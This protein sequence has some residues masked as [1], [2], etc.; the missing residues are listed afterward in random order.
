MR[1]VNVKILFGQLPHTK[2][3]NR[4]KKFYLKNSIASLLIIT[5]YHLLIATSMTLIIALMPTKA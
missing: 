3:L 5:Q 4:V 1:I 2:F